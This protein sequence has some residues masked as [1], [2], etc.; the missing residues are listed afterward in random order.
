MA[1]QPSFCARQCA[2]CFIHILLLLRTPQ[3]PQRPSSVWC[4][5]SQRQV[6]LILSTLSADPDR[7]SQLI[8]SIISLTGKEWT[9][10][11]CMFSTSNPNSSNGIQTSCTFWSNSNFEHVGPTA[12]MGVL[13]LV[14]R[15]GQP[16][17][18]S[19]A[20]PH[21]HNPQHLLLPWRD[22]C[23]SHS[24]GSFICCDSL[25][26]LVLH[27]PSCSLSSF[28]TNTSRLEGHSQGRNRRNRLHNRI[29]SSRN[30]NP[31]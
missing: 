30:Y 29:H 4:C 14:S 9:G 16:L 22:G 2:R 12:P 24:D 13:L 21:L 28:L 17:E 7:A 26:I 23:S 19:L 10:P 1:S 25:H 31:T 6:C 15:C 3:C 11:C 5:Y 18:A 20:D 27:L 8:Q